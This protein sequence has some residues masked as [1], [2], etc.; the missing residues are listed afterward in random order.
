[1][2]TA[3]L[4]KRPAPAG[5]DDTSVFAALTAH[6]AGTADCSEACLLAWK[7]TVPPRKAL[8]RGEP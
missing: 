7:Q 8:L 1:M 6:V 5:R 2:V 4:L 3:A